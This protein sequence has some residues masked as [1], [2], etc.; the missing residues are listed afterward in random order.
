[1]KKTCMLVLTVLMAASLGTAIGF[2]AM[3]VNALEHGAADEN[4]W[5]QNA[6]MNDLTINDEGASVITTTA[7]GAMTYNATALD[8]TKD[9]YITF[10]SDIINAGDNW[11]G[12]YLVDDTTAVM[13]GTINYIAGSSDAVKIGAIMRSGAMILGS[14]YASTTVGQVRTTVGTPTDICQ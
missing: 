9:N 10:R 7:N 8:V 14:G 3:P 12:V 4:G 11:L 5:V 2:T 6:N 13:N 1:M